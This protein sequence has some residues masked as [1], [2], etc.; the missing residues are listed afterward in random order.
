VKNDSF[1]TLLTPARPGDYNADGAVN[2][3]DYAVW[4][5]D[6]GTQGE[7]AADANSDGSVDA[8]DYVLWRH[9]AVATGSGA[10]VPASLQVPESESIVTV[11]VCALAIVAI[12][13]RWAARSRIV[14]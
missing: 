6:F 12:G 8:A 13:G 11:S 2:E 1:V 5:H 14:I 9:Y 10:S 4:R 3:L 7:L